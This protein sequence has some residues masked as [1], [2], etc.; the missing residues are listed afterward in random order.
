M[1]MFKVYL[2]NLDL[3]LTA[4]AL[5]PLFE[6]FG[7]G[8]EICIAT[9]AEGKSRGF[10]IVLFKDP[11]KG[12]LAIETLS[13]RKISGRTVVINE[14]VKKGKK[15]QPAT[16]IP[17]N[18]PLGP[19][20]FARPGAGFSRG[21]SG[22]ARMGG[23]SGRFIRNP[24]RLMGQPG[25]VGAPGAPGGTGAPGSPVAPGGTGAPGVPG[26][27]GAPG[28]PG[29]PRAVTPPPGA[30]RLGSTPSALPRPVTPG[31]AA[32]ATPR[33]AGSPPS[34]GSPPTSRPASPRP[35]ATGQGD[36]P[37]SGSGS[38]AGAAPATPPRPRAVKKS[39]PPAEGA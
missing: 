5:K 36:A 19:R 35:A 25:V 37:P 18:S 6:P 9:D 7:D 31:T 15:T 32:G 4:E 20:A 11:L 26:A 2:G 27:P 30:V 1:P 3:K 13:G 10:A 14:A 24:R 29:A 34:A 23:A 38:D 12:Q 22:G 8:E 33:P 21:A 16:R 28:V 39:L 17:R